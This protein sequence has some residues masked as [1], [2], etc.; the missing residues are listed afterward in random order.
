MSQGAGLMLACEEVPSLKRAAG[1][2]D[3]VSR[4]VSGPETGDE[5][6]LNIRQ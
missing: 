2:A 5:P 3:L 4:I 6:G 1:R